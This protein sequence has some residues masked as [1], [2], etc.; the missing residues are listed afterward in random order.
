MAVP[1]LP[2]PV[3]GATVNGTVP[4]PLADAC[5]SVSQSTLLEAVH[6]HPAV[7]ATEM[8]PVPPAC[9]AACDVG[10]IV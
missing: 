6:G 10:V 8:L 4:G 5:P 9:S 2:G 3:V 1:V 7:V